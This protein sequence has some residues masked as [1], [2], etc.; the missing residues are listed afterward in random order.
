MS[1][2]FLVENRKFSLALIQTNNNSKYSKPYM[3]EN[4]IAHSNENTHIAKKTGKRSSYYIVMQ[5]S[6][7]KQQQ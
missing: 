1:W 5:T 3:K 2:N 6:M 4:W 7:N